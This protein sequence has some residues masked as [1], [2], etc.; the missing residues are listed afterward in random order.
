VCKALGVQGTLP[1]TWDMAHGS[2][3]KSTAVWVKAGVLVQSSMQEGAT[4]PNMSSGS[5]NGMPTAAANC[6]H[7]Q[8]T[9]MLVC[10]GTLLELY[11]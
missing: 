11:R 7:E 9:L 1:K 10:C 8:V 5:L 4:H 3:V 6:L 2:G